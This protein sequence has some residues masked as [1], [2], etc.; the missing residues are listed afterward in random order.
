MANLTEMYNEADRLREAGDYE[1]AAQKLNELLEQDA[2]H[3][4]AHLALAVVLS[5]LGKYEESAQHGQR[6]CELEPED[7]FNF[8]A[9]SITLQR[10]YAG[11]GNQ[12]F[13]QLAED[14][15]ARSQQLQFE[16]HQRQQQSG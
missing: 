12:Q 10:A 4:L 2:D 8:T 6:A 16:Q 5:K 3:V 11:T 9:L 14:A 7:P 1:A 15:M 13:V